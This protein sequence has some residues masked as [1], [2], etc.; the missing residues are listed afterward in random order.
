MLHTKSIS[1]N[2]KIPLISVDWLLIDLVRT[3]MCPPHMDQR[4]CF[5]GVWVRHH[6]SLFQHIGTHSSLT[7]KLQ[8]LKDDDF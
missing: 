1:S 3:K 7:G 4:L 2:L 6:P 5:Q 8:E